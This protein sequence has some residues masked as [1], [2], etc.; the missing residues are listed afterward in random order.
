MKQRLLIS[1]AFLILLG[2][3]T[4]CNQPTTPQDPFLVKAKNPVEKQAPPTENSTE[5]ATAQVNQQ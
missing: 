1:M 5:D 3:L 2:A 4:S